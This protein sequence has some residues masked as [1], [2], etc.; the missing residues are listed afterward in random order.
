MRK[1]LVEVALPLDAIN[2]AS[3]RKR[4]SRK[5]VAKRNVN[6]IQSDK[7]LFFNDVFIFVLRKIITRKRNYDA[8]LGVL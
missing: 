1:K 4:L 3:V 2:V 5:N 7:Y 8:I 6:A